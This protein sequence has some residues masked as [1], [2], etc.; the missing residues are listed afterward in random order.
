MVDT[1]NDAKISQDEW[2]EGCNKGWISADADTARDMQNKS[3][4]NGSSGSSQ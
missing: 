2:K 4:G 3:G 1:S